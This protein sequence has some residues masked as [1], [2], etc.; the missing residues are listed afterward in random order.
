MLTKWEGG[1]L[2]YNDKTNLGQ[3]AGSLTNQRLYSTG[4]IPWY[5]WHVYIYLEIRLYL[6]NVGFTCTNTDRNSYAYTLFSE[7]IMGNENLTIYTDLNTSMGK[8]VYIIPQHNT[9]DVGLT[10][11][12]QCFMKLSLL[13]FY[14]QVSESVSQL[15]I[16]LVSQSV[17]QP[18]S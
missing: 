4:A 11:R 15:V 8:S 1:E 9:I 5:T 13:A 14:F 16:E 18:V 2:F 12:N 6:N 17:S 10:C 3:I 7:Y